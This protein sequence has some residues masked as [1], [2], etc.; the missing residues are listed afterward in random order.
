M[1]P[2]MRARGSVVS[3]G[4]LRS[5]LVLLIFTRVFCSQ[6]DSKSGCRCRGEADNQEDT[7]VIWFECLLDWYENHQGRNNC[8]G[9]GSA[10]LPSGPR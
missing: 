6:A 1:R 4:G 5:S 8:S 9:Q 2:S 7:R 10:A 3:M